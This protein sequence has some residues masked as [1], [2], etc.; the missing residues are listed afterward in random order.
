M[1]NL[2][3]TALAVVAIAACGPSNKE[4]SGAKTARYHGDK[5]AI[6]NG[7]KEVVAAKYTIE[8][9]DET[10]LGMNTT[11][12][13]YTPEGLAASERDMRD[14]PDKSLGILF[15]V[16]VLPDGDNWV[17]SIEPRIQRYFAGR[18]NTDVLKLDDPSIPG[19]A[20]E[21]VDVLA[22]DINAALKQYEVK[23]P[24][25]QLA[26]PP[27]APATAPAPAPAPEPAPAGAGY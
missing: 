9:S 14:V 11:N 13:W 4:L 23:S 6:F 5:I 20:T 15:I 25:G 17:V 8:K 2:I 3:L 22:F 1:R 7:A 16:K 12:R 19:W 21:K 26:P 10:V 27:T 24:G 18:P